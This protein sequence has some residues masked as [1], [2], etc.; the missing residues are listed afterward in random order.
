MKHS[1]SPSMSYS[2][3]VGKVEY[4]DTVVPAMAGGAMGVLAVLIGL[5][6]IVALFFLFAYIMMVTY[7]ASVPEM[8]NVPK[9]DSFWT[10]VWF[11][12][13]IIM[14]GFFFTPTTGIIGGLSRK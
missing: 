8:F 13:F 14:L 12:V 1:S 9:I 5:I 11:A 4:S 3:P 10:A 7:N 2:T 6:L